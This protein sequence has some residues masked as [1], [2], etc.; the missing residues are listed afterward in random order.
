MGRAVPD[1]ARA[2]EP[3]I[4]QEPFLDGALVVDTESLLPVDE[5]LRMRE[6]LPGRARHGVPCPPVR[7]VQTP[8]GGRLEHE[9]APDPLAPRLARALDRRRSHG[10]ALQ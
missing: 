9:P 10:R 2:D 3:S 6:R 4:G 7:L 8:D 1:V 5:L